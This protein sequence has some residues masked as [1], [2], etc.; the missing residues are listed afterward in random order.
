[1]KLKLKKMNSDINISDLAQRAAGRVTTKE[2]TM[3]YSVSSSTI[4]NRARKCGFTPL[5]R[6]RKTF[7]KPTKLQVEILKAIRMETLNAVGSRYGFSRQY[8]WSLAKRWAHYS[9]PE[10]PEVAE[11]ETSH[12]APVEA[13]DVEKETLA[14]VI[15][16][17]LS[18]GEMHML[19][20]RQSVCFS[21]NQIA[22]EILRQS[23][24]S[25]NDQKT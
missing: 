2:L 7:A 17:R 19:R 3:R 11:S 22:R 13:H 18:E 21:C 8:V 24:E 4:S 25:S 6:G 20:R 9:L 12:V 14:H 10:E 15:T 23:L 1:M 16:F 5:K